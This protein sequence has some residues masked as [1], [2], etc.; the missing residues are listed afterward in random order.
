MMPWIYIDGEIVRQNPHIG[1][2][3]KLRY[4]PIIKVINRITF[5]LIINTIFSPE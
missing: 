2:K 4:I 5:L 3:E 1:S